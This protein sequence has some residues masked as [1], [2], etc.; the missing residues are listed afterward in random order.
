MNSENY[1]QSNNNGKSVILKY[2]LKIRDYIRNHIYLQIIFAIL[3]VFVVIGG[4]VFLGM[5]ALLLFS[6][7]TK[8]A[9]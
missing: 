9:S 5:V 6:S 1:D 2:Y 4:I 3:G 7:I 8:V